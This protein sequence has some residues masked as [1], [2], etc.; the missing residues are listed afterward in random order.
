MDIELNEDQTMLQDMTRR[1]LEDRSPIGALRKQVNAGEG[2][3]RD[4]WKE[5]AELGWIALFVPEEN[6]GIAESAGGVADAAIVAEE[7]GR[8]VFSGPFLSTCAVS[9]AIAQSGSAEQREAH[10]PGLAAGETLG[11]WC[12]SGRGPM[13][14][15]EPGAITA[16]ASGNGFE[17]N[18]TAAFVQDAADADL[19]LV[20]AKDGNGVSQFVI[21]ATSAGVSIEAMEALDLGRRLHVVKFNGVKAEADALLGEAGKAAQALE[22]QI[23]TVVTLQCAEIV[24]VADRAFEFTLEWVNDRYAFGRPIGSYQGLKH[25]LARHCGHLEGAKA[26]AAYAARAVQGDAP[27]AAIAVSVAKSHC[28]RM[29]TEIIRDCLQMHGGIGLTWEHDIHLYLRRAVSNEQLWGS[30]AAHH[31]RLCQLTG[32]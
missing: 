14:G 12:I 27:D 13:A 32:L 26:A 2:F 20:T 11:A 19:L 22:K 1:F 6:G 17:L 25:R 21:P 31:E 3:D 10:L 4:V 30:P 16:T 9:Y 24:G 23:Q 29:A 5:G 18:G 8:V 28:G 7:L 15:L